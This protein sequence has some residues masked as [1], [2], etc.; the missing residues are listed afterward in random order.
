MHEPSLRTGSVMCITVNEKTRTIY[1]GTFD[2]LIRAWS[3]HVSPE[4]NLK[5][6]LIFFVFLLFRMDK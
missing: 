3:I 1:C 4:Q 2:R 6:F 5:V